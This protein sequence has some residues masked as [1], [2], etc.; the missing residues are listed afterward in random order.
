MP[1]KRFA[2][3]ARG[4]QVERSAKPIPD[5]AIDFSDI[6]ESTDEKLRKAKRVGRPRCNDA[7]LLIAIRIRSSLLDKIQKVAKAEGKPYQTFIHEILENKMKQI[8]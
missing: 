3:S 6:P 1:I 8:Q 5:S 4:R 7:K 2:T